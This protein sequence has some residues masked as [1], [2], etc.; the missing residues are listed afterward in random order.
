MQLWSVNNILEYNSELFK[1]N[2]W[3]INPYR[4]YKQPVLY[5]CY[6]IELI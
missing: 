6:D 1:T 5:T 3:Q 2:L 4:T